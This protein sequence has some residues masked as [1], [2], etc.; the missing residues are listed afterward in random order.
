[1]EIKSNNKIHK[2]N[3]E[4]HKKQ[5]RTTQNTLRKH[6]FSTEKQIEINVKSNN[7]NTKKLR[8]TQQH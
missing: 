5:L 8:T 2:A 4:K 3:E 1:M 6:S 7:K